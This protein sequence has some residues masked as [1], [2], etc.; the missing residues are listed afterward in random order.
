[1]KT[2][3]ER[4]TSEQRLA[5]S[6]RTRKET[7]DQRISNEPNLQRRASSFDEERTLIKNLAINSL[8]A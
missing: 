6:R 2:G 3:R 4:E 7:I 1:M 8:K 5:P